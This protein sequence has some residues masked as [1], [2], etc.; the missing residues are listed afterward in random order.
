MS[1]IGPSVIYDTKITIPL[2]NSD[3]GL[4]NIVNAKFRTL[5][6]LTLHI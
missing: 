5:K 4:L 6:Y 3:Y 2:V 1:L